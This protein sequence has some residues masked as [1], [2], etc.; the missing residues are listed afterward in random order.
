MAT[1]IKR[2]VKGSP[3][4]NA[5]GDSNFENLNVEKLERDGS[6][7]M[8]DKLVTPGV[9]SSSTENGLRLFNQAGDLVAILGPNNSQNLI[10]EGNIEVGEQSQGANLNLSGGDITARNLF[11][12]GKIISSELGV[13]Y[14]V[15]G[16]GDIFRG[17]AETVNNQLVI[18][19]NVILKLVTVEGEFNIGNEVTGSQSNVTATVTR[20][21]GNSIY[22]ELEN[23]TDE[24][25]VGE[26]IS[27]FSNT[28]VLSV[29]VDASSYEKGQK[30]KLFGASIPGTSTPAATP[31]ASATKVG[32]GTGNTY[33]YW[34]T[35]FRYS[36]GKVSAVRKIS[37]NVVHRLASEFNTDN[38]ISLRLSRSSVE[39]GMLVY[40]A[41]SD[42]LSQSI[43]IDVLGHDAL[44]NATTNIVYVDYGGFAN[45]EWST[46]NQSGE[47]T[48]TSGM[49][50][51]PL[52]GNNLTL[53]GWIFGT[54]DEVQG[55]NKIILDANYD[56]NTN[57]KVEFVHDN[58]QGIQQ[59]IDDQRELNLLGAEFPNG[60]YYSS[61]LKVPSDFEISG[62]GKQTI[63]KQIPWNFDYW[64]DASATNERGN[65]F[66]PLEAAPQNI[67]FRNLSIDGNFICNTRY[68]E[69]SATYLVNIP[70]GENVNFISMRIAN[71]TGG[72]IFSFNTK[73]LRVQDCEIVDGGGTSYLGENLS[74]IYGG[75][76]EYMTITN[77]L[78]ENF[79]NPVDVSV[80]RIGTI[81]GNTVRN[82]GSG[83]LIYGSAHLLSSPNLLM[84]PDNEFLPSPDTMDSDYNA[85]NIIL[86][87][88]VD[89]ISP[90]YLYI[91]RG[92]ISY[93]GSENRLNQQG[94][95]IPG[96]AVTLDSTINM[97]TQV[98]NAEE[99]KDSYTNTQFG[100]PFINFI[101]PNTGD[102]GRNSGYFQ[103]KVLASDIAELPTLSKL[104]TD[105]GD[106][107][108]AGEE[109][110][111]LA[112]RILATTYT[113]TD[114]GER[115]PIEASEFSVDGINKY[116]TVTL[117]D[118]TD[119]T[120]FVVNDIV[121]IFDHSSTPDITNTE[122]TVV[123]KIEDGLLKKIK[124][125][126]PDE[127]DLNGAVD[128]EQTGYVTIRKTFIIAKGRIN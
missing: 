76:A 119:F 84:G 104:I 79:L 46:K 38:H 62:S 43:L 89:Y 107:L 87:P 95:E 80:S 8:T 44:G 47:Y 53:E 21:E 99:L 65:I 23:E 60:T 127:T 75:S 69:F 108:V 56:L 5:E 92:V 106:E 42:D 52:S 34:I 115:I 97:L 94:N 39:Y 86:E 83:L 57:S 55:S 50:H 112:Y 105:H 77:N 118:E 24:F 36:D 26:T 72:G 90:S 102:Y 18:T 14:G 128:G 7:P 30:L 124:V 113:Y 6:V 67:F 13:Q 12:S 116:I 61:K 101:S 117:Q 41:T 63:I 111:G 71:S 103:F 100:E 51:F 29:I 121:K 17:T 54:V 19:T 122:G 59:F 16:D 48:E 33:Y 2:L 109:I 28:G 88:G 3:L 31:A 96:T 9:Q 123:D 27:Y 25:I 85:V 93:L 49:I 37:G 98:N 82:C 20:V 45:T 81:V 126:L 91:E 114:E 40:R 1:I 68:D 22:V 74:P 120:T 70:N 32:S 73:Y 4:T 125:K 64:D 58:T 78:F 66:V 11:I 35:Q 15:S 10:I 110:L